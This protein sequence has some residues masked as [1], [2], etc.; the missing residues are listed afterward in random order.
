MPKLTITIA[1][2][3]GDAV[4]DLEYLRQ[5]EETYAAIAKLA[6]WGFTAEEHSQDATIES[7]N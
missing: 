5:L 4:S 7:T 2:D 1:V 6:P 3:T